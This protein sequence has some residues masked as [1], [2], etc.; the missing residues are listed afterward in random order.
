MNP[1]WTPW[2]S[3]HAGVNV[4]ADLSVLGINVKHWT[5]YAPK[6]F[7]LMPAAN[8]ATQQLPDAISNEAYPTT[9]VQAT[10]GNGPYTFTLA[11]GTHLPEG[12]T[13]SGSGVITGTPGTVTGCQTNPLDV[14]VTDA[15]AGPQL[16]PCRCGCAPSCPRSSTPPPSRWM[17]TGTPWT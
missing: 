15:R 10:G 8:I 14:T 5:I 12:M 16:G 4:T 2:W 11:N 9:Q 17:R 1:A 3:K 6:P 13:M 7:D